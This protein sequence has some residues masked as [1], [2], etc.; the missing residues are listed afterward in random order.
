MY[1]ILSMFAATRQLYLRKG[2]QVFVISS[3]RSMCSRAQTVDIKRR[4]S[5][6]DKI[7]ELNGRVRESGLNLCRSLSFKIR[8]SRAAACNM[9]MGNCKPIKDARDRQIRCIVFRACL[10]VMVVL[11]R[12][13]EGGT[14]VRH[15]WQQHSVLILPARG[16][17]V[18][19]GYDIKI[20]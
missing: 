17:P 13:R 6:I 3:C 18:F 12:A 7:K 2:G 15:S 20:G 9:F 5:T 11:C 4:V 1:E 16:G 19:S 8:Y 14:N 10:G